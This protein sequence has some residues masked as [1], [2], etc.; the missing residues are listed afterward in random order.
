MILTGQ[1]LVDKAREI[2]TEAHRG[3]YRAD[4][5]TPYIEHPRAVAFRALADLGA[6]YDLEYRCKVEAVANDH[7]VVEDHADVWPLHRLR[8]EGLESI[9]PD[10][11]LLTHDLSDS[12]LTYI[13]RVRDSRRPIALAVKLADIACNL[14]DVRRIPD[15]NRQRSLIAKWEM[16]RWILTH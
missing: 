3:Q 7:D 5:V 16:A 15:P 4:G 2:A 8:E 1:A 10:L 11:A 13:L 12:Y 6:G 14:A 9:V